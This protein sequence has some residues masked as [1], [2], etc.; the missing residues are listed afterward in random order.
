[1][2]QHDEEQNASSWPEPGPLIG[3]NSLSLQTTHLPFLGMGGSLIFFLVI[4]APFLHGQHAF[5]LVFQP[6]K[7]AVYLHESDV[8]DA[9]D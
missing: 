1:M 8:R 4:R 7:L 3:F 6:N 2:R 5:Q 9:T